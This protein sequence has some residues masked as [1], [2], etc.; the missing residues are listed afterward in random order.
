MGLLVNDPMQGHTLSFIKSLI[1]P[2][3]NYHIRITD[4]VV[5]AFFTT[6]QGAVITGSYLAKQY[7]SKQNGGNG[8]VLINTGSIAGKLSHIH[9]SKRHGDQQRFNMVT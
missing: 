3:F 5:A 4:F 9:R 7:M 1:H 8:G 6:L 2:C